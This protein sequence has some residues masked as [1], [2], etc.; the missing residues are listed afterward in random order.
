MKRRNGEAGNYIWN[1]IGGVLNAAQSVVMLMIITRLLGLAA[2]GVYSIAFA[3]G[4]LFLYLGNYGVRNYQVSDLEEEYAFREY[5]AHRALTVTLMFAVSVGYSIYGY[6]RSGY[7]VEKAWTVLAMCVLKMIDCIEEV[8]E[9]RYHQRGRLDRTGQLMTIRLLVS[10][11]GM[12]VAMIV[13]RDLLIATWVA[14][15]LAAV[16]DVIVIYAFRETAAWQAGPIRTTA[17]A[18]LM[19]SCFPVCAANFLSFYL[20]NAPKYAIDAVLGET[21]QAEYNFIA[22][23]VFVI[24]MLN[25]FLYQPVLVDMTSAWNGKD[26]QTFSRIFRKILVELLAIAVVVLVGA[27]LLGIPVLSVL[28]AT[29]LTARKGDLMIILVGSIF[30]A[31]NGFMSAV[32]TITRDQNRIPVMYL[33]GAICSLLVTQNMTVRWGIRGAV[34]AFA[35]S[36]IVVSVL[37]TVVYVGT[38]LT[39]R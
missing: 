18:G 19:R 31:Y 20:I 16:A 5:V 6:V 37:L 34:C 25:M 12:A 21:V 13:T 8:F 2:A 24:Q 26:R 10:M 38:L 9:G 4:N 7:S 36:M 23:P 33:V 3:T 29:D 39:N 1:S 14:V 35:G 17:I 28:Y 15:I 27:W 30:L 32:L 22:M 11:A